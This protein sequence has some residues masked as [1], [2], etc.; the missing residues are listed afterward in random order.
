MRMGDVRRA[1]PVV[2]LA[3]LSACSAVRVSYDHADW[4][5]A[6]LAARYV[7]LDRSQAAALRVRLDEF[8]AWHRRQELPRYA[9]LLDEA[10]ARL[11]RG[12]TRADVLWAI[13]SVRNRWHV[14]GRE[15]ARDLAPL[16]MTLDRAQLA[17][18]ARRFEEDN[19]KFLIEKLPNDPERA[20][21]ARSDWLCER[22]EDWTGRLTP[23]QRSHV[24]ALVRAFPELPALRLQ[25]RVRRQT[26]LLQL[27]REGNGDGGLDARLVTLLADP[28]AGRSDRYRLTLAD[29][30]ERFSDMLVELDRSLAPI[31]RA[32]AVERLRGYAAQFRVLA[33]PGGGEQGI[34]EQASM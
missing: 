23:A 17:G 12:L 21:Q 14:L 15:A 28:E 1:L 31:Q 9:R 33:V 7:D 26:G 11:E 18:L 6:R 27:L 34:Q 30:H 22:L 8:H 24:T 29:W 2:L 25:D 10:A 4:V 16:L 20:I 13:A 5:L 19:Q 3:L 32:T